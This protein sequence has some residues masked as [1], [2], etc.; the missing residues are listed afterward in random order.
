MQRDVHTFGGGGRGGFFYL[1]VR[2]DCSL[3]IIAIAAL[4][5]WNRPTGASGADTRFQG[6]VHIS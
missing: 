2:D 4:G 3:V 6:C 5:G 1:S